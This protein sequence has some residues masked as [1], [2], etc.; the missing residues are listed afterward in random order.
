MHGSYGAIFI[1]KIKF[2]ENV[3]KR[4]KAL[5]IKQIK[6]LN[7]WSKALIQ[8]NKKQN[9]QMIFFIFKPREVNLGLKN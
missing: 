9:K 7:K 3:K 6:I 4:S 1:K 8:V 5:F 2:F